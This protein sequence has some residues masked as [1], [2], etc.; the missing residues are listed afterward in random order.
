MSPDELRSA[1]KSLG[2]TQPGLRALLRN[3]YSL[4]TIKRWEKGEYPVPGT[5][6]MI[7]ESRTD[8]KKGE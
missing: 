7:L 2:L 3:T 8:A 4:R 1:R 5:V 6:E